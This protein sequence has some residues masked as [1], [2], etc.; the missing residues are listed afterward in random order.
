MT[1]LEKFMG[2]NP[3][4]IQPAMHPYICLAVIE[5]ENWL[6]RVSQAFTAMHYYFVIIII[7]L[8][9]LIIYNYFYLYCNICMT[10]NFSDK[11][12]QISCLTFSYR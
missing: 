8:S 1:P 11:L 7:I 5:S 9:I 3:N 12:K 2:P 10:V 6:K 4:F